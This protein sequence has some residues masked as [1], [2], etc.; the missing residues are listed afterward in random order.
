MKYP[1]TKT[2]INLLYVLDINGDCDATYFIYGEDENYYYG[3]DIKIKK[4][5]VDK[6]ISYYKKFFFTTKEKRKEF[7]LNYY[8]DNKEKLRWYKEVDY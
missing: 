3:V 6:G 8:K 7:A 2:T 5:K 1:E 4:D